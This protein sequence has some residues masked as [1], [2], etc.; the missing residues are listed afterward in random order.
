MAMFGGH[1]IGN[2]ILEIGTRK[3]DEEQRPGESFSDVI[4][5]PT[6]FMVPAVAN[7]SAAFRSFW[8]FIH[9]LAV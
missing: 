8:Y 2:N 6:S 7:V 3:W 5:A 9:F 4:G 1:A